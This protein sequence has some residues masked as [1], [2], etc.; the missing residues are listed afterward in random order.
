MSGS[1]ECCNRR[2]QQPPAAINQVDVPMALPRQTQVEE[3][4]RKRHIENPLPFTLLHI[5]AG[6]ALCFSPLQVFKSK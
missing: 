2:A 3:R 4:C 6:I 1:F 5:P